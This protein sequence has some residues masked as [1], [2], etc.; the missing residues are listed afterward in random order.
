M[1]QKRLNGFKEV[2]ETFFLKVI[3]LHSVHPLSP[4]GLDLLPKFQKGG[5]TGSQFL[6]RGCWKRG[7]D[8]F[9]PG[10]GG[11]VVVT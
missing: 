3:Y 11:I 2:C 7:G 5:L 4:G 8:I 1:Y 6:E 10:E 9:K